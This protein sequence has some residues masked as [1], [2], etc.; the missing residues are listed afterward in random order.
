MTGTA[1]DAWNALADGLREAGR[2]LAEA[3]TKL[4]SA[5]RTDGYR[6]L[7]RALNNQLGRLETDT[8]RP[9]FAAFNG[10]REK[11]FM[12]N[13]DCRYWITDLRDDRR[14]CITGNVGESVFQ[15]I[16]V[17]S[18][19]GVAD[20]AAVARID[21][22]DLVVD[23]DGGFGLTLAPHGGDLE[24]PGG[25][26]SVWVRHLHNDIRRDRAGWCR[27]EPIDPPAE[28]TVRDDAQFTRDLTRLG[29]FVSRLPDAFQYAVAADAASPNSVRHWAAMAGGAAFTEP[30]IHYLRGA[31]QLE[32]G[33]AL[34]VEGE[35]PGC[36]HWNILLY[37]RFLNSLDHRNRVVSRT[38]ANSTIIDGRYRFVLAGR[39]P[40]AP[41]YDWLDTEGRRFGL[42]VMRFLQADAVPALPNVR[43]VGLDALVGPR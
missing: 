13:P 10:W 7:L 5:E 12:D 37:S 36:R 3:T 23:A 14:Y 40:G 20:A 41:G 6:A 34:V 39:D 21:T 2:K 16:T 33:E 38:T 29:T 35:L 22:D 4:D 11:F 24:L 28:P 25:A 42:F 15:S 31:W 17:Y 26:R 1:E 32:D 27:I 30:D 43:V 18:G 8:E 19:T 9:E